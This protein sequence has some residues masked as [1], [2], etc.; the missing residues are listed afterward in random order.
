MNPLTLVSGPS[1]GGIMHH[2]LGLFDYGPTNR[3]VLFAPWPD[4]WWSRSQ[5][6]WLT[7]TGTP[8]L[9]WSPAVTGA[10]STTHGFTNGYADE[11]QSAGS[12]IGFYR[13]LE[14]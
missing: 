11:M 7:L 5:G 9:A 10:W 4:V 3:V 6:A 13:L 12:P 14:P 2:K 8:V 1:S